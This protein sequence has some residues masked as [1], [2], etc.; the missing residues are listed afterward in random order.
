MEEV[1]AALKKLTKGGLASSKVIPIR[2]K[3]KQT[4]CQTQNYS[5]TE[6]NCKCSMESENS[7]L[8][9]CLGFGQK[10]NATVSVS[11]VEIFGGGEEFRSYQKQREDLPERAGLS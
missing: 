8:G 11:Q 3:N 6:I 1:W 5:L 9:E 7:S 4:K 10:N 2:M